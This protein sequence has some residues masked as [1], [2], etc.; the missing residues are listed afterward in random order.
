MDCYRP[1]FVRGLLVGLDR[2][3]DAKERA[4]GEAGGQ[5]TRALDQPPPSFVRGKAGSGSRGR[6]TAPPLRSLSSPRVAPGGLSKKEKPRRYARGKYKEA[7]VPDGRTPVQENT[8]V[9]CAVKR[10]VIKDAAGTTARR[11]TDHLRPLRVSVQSYRATFSHSQGQNPNLPHRNTDAHFTSI[12]RPQQ[13]GF[14]ATLCARG[15]LSRCSKTASLV[16]YFVCS[17]GHAGGTFEVEGTFSGFSSCPS[18][19]LLRY[20]M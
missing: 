12:S 10:V 20:L 1:T 14:N 11:W 4:L 19:L 8:A 7:R 6:Q 18:K 3:S 15:D 16:D 17:G 2:L 5:L 13:V 9:L